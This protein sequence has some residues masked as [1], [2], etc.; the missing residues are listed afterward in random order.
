MNRASFVLVLILCAAITSAGA[1]TIQAGIFSVDASTVAVHARISGGAI[2]NLPF[3]N[4]VV[5]LF[6]ESSTG[7]ELGTPSGPFAIGKAGVEASE[8]AFSYQ[9]FAATP[10]SNVTWADGDEVELF[11]ISVSA[12]AGPVLMEVRNP[13]DAGANGDWYVEIGGEDLTNHS[14]PFYAQSTELPLP[15]SLTSFTGKIAQ[16]GTGVVLQWATA[17]EVNNYGYTVQRKQEGEPVFTDLPGAFVAG[18][19]TTL[20]P[21]SYTFLDNSALPAGR[22]VYRLRQQDLNGAVQYSQSIMMT[23][24][25]TDVA[26]VAPRE[27]QLLQ[28]YPNPFNPSTRLKFSVPQAGPATMTI[29][30]VLGEAV[31]VLFEDVAEAGRYYVLPF[32]GAGLASGAYF[33]RL[34]TQQKTDVRKMLLVR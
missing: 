10:N 11:S 29:F 23:I 16:N 18:H 28:N 21:Q 4:V 12:G 32:D 14:S 9:K 24:A 34:V 25:L 33:Y 3:S 19:G 20:E 7:L 22:Y 8:G 13:A 15:V 17:T 26:E 27:F 31:Q 2:T 5:T 6:W 1:Q 30:N